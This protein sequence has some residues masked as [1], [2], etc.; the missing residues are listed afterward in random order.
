MNILVLN[1]SPKGKHSVTIQ[2]CLYLEQIYSKHKF[3]YLNASQKI[4]LYK[5]DFTEAVTKIKEADIIIFCYPVYTFL[6]PY[7]LHK[8]IELLY[9]NN[10]D[11]KDKFV[12]QITTSKRFFDIT[13][14]NYIKENCFDFD[15]K[16]INGLSADMED[17][18]C[19][20]GRKQATSFFDKLL[21]DVE[22]DIYSKRQGVTPKPI[23]EI[24]KPCLEN[25]TKT[26]TKDVL[27]LTNCSPDDENLRNM[28]D[29]FK[30]SFKYETREINIAEYKFSSGCIGC[31]NCTVSGK[32]IFRD[33]FD[34][35][36]RNDIQ[37]AD[38]IV[39]AFT[40]KNHYTESSFKCYDDRQFC[41]GHRAVTTGMP[42]GYIIAGDYYNESNLQVIVEGRSEIG[43]VYLSGVATDTE[44]IKN[45]STSL[46]YTIENTMYKSTNFYGVGGTKIFRDLIYLMR[47]MMKADHQYYKKTGIYDFPHNQK[48]KMLQM[49]MVGAMMSIPKLQKEMKGKMNEYIL[50]PYNKIIEQ[51]NT[52]DKK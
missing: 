4:N 46:G 30:A 8:F 19:E 6:A 39:Y 44:S 48:L 36:L 3:E 14:H 31:L 49:S 40:I 52:I 21:F 20:K 32:C 22:N 15:M 23:T 12:T 35:F 47:G 42:V 45:L 43:K 28:I 26:N 33:N 16:Y 34:D 24:Y 37:T 51:A 2:T 9:E 18:L 50:M 7:Q 13:A 27:I 11:M 38:S 25:V 17:L 41:N 5:R 29:D 10:I 1:G